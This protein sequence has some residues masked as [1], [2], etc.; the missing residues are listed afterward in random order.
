MA[1]LTTFLERITCQRRAIL[2]LASVMVMFAASLA[3][4][5][6][7]EP[8]GGT[9]ESAEQAVAIVP[10]LVGPIGALL[11][12]G[13]IRRLRRRAIGAAWFLLLPS[14]AF[15]I[16]E[17]AE[18]LTHA[19]SLP[20]GISEPSLLAALLVQLP[21]GLV[22]FVLARLCLT[23]VRRVARFLVTARPWP[24]ATVA[25]PAWPLPIVSLAYVP[26]T[27]GAHRGRAPPRLR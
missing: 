16:Q 10:P 2:L 18:R 7:G 6:A 14:A 5:I 12:L 13:A 9:G 3:T 27:T 21:F 22:A 11:V 23:A 4:H 26:A 1:S 24:R 15:G 17:L 25:R 8:P 20:G 19:E